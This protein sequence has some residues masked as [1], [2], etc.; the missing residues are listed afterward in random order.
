MIKCNLPI[1]CNIKSQ[2]T[3]VTQL[4]SSYEFVLNGV[5]NETRLEL[6]DIQN[7]VSLLKVDGNHGTSTNPTYLLINVLCICKHTSTFVNTLANTL[8]VVVEQIL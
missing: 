4:Q 3:S 2:Y 8:K 5:E 7:P 1:I 6:L